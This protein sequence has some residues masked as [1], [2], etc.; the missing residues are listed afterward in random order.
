M[1]RVDSYSIYHSS[2]AYL[3]VPKQCGV[4]VA[5]LVGGRANPRHGS[6]HREDCLHWAAKDRIEMRFPARAYCASLGGGREA[7]LDRA[8]F[9]T[10]YVDAG[11][12][13]DEA[14]WRH[15]IEIAGLEPNA[16]RRRLAS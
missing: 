3:G 6:Y 12:I 1:L 14:V 2:N 10:S 11:D 7:V 16:V 13:N 9:H 15:A 4:W 8:L 5:D